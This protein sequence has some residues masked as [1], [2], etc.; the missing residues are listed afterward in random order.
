MPRPLIIIMLVSLA[1]LLAG[2]L[3]FGGANMGH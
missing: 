1:A 3:T 2:L